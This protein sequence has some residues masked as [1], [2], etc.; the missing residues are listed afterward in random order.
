MPTN[1]DNM[2]PLINIILLTSVYMDF[3][4]KP[5]TKMFIGMCLYMCVCIYMYVYENMCH[6]KMLH[7]NLLLH[8]HQKDVSNMSNIHILHVYLLRLQVKSFPLL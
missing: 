6:I 2:N 5:S 4:N 3:G 7:Y 8:E 1:K